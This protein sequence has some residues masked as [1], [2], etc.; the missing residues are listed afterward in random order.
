MTTD[1]K[2]AAEEAALK[3]A[4]ELIKK[5]DEGEDFEKL[6]KENS[7]DE[8]TASKGGVLDPFGH[9]A[10]VTEFEEAALDLEDGEYTK[11]P[12]KTTFGYHIILRVSQKEKPQI[13]TVR[14]DIVENLYKDKMTADSSLE[15]TALEELRKENKIEIH[16]KT[17]KSQYDT[18]L[19]NAKKSA[20]NS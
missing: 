2:T 1:E 19:V 16:D 13:K 15:I 8:G 4:K 3:K 14:D 18:Y 10:M 7:D 11:E 12:V 9:G 20:K 5:L 17:L 6:A